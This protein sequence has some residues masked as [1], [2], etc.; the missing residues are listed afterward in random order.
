ML[1]QQTAAACSDWMDSICYLHGKLMNLEKLDP[2]LQVAEVGCAYHL[3]Q[4]KIKNIMYNSGRYR[5]NHFK[6]GSSSSNENFKDQFLIQK[7]FLNYFT[8]R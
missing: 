5:L 3:Q 4:K 2:L 7:H 1:L 6:T 8:S